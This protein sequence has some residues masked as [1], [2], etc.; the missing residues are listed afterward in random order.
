MV[1]RDNF[2]WQHRAAPGGG[3]AG[4]AS[5]WTNEV[6]SDRD[7]AGSMGAED[8]DGRSLRQHG[9]ICGA[10]DQGSLSRGGTTRAPAH[11]P[12]KPLLGDIVSGSAAATLAEAGTGEGGGFGEEVW[13]STLG[14]E[15]MRCR[16][17][18]FF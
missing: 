1:P 9:L 18:R 7:V 6:C 10:S 8:R 4:S 3:V 12:G 2:S 17:Y 15:E 13:S 16:V 5:Y 14:G 11:P